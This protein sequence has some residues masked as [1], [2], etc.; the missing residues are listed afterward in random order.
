M[1]RFL[2][3]ILFGVLALLAFGETKRQEP[4]VQFTGG[5][6][7]HHDLVMHEIDR[8]WQEFSREQ[9][10]DLLILVGP[11]HQDAGSSIFTTAQD[12]QAFWSDVVLATDLQ[13]QAVRDGKM[14]VNNTIFRPEHSVNL[15]LELVKK[16]LPNTRVLPLLIRS[17]A[18]QE[19]VLHLAD[20][21]RLNAH[22][23]VAVVASVDFSHYRSRD[24]AE[25][26]DSKSLAA[27]QQFD[28]S[29]LSTFGS[30]N[31]DSGQSIIL[32]SE[33]VC[34]SHTCTWQELYH[35]NSSDLPF[36]NPMV[37]TRYFSLFLSS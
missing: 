1:K 16:Y 5:V 29:T 10:P 34:P 35:G 9:T 15:H 19:N 32:L 27:I 12:P 20:Y 3:L 26:F 23:N 31:M 33:I 21:L 14:T 22:G 6:V 37:T 24:E 8:F 18:S 36:Q 7:P 17:D 4:P 28:Y 30:D 11:D 25:T 13:D 2:P